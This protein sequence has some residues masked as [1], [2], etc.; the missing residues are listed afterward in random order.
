MCGILGIVSQNRIINLKER[1][2]EA[3]N[4]M[5]HRGPD[6]EGFYADNNCILVHKRLAIIDIE[7]G[8]QPLYN[9]DRRY[10]LVFNGEIYNYQELRKILI[11]RGHNIR[12]NSD[13]EVIVHLFEDEGSECLYKLR[14][15]FAFAIWDKKERRLFLAR[16]RL[17]IKP[18]YYAILSD[19]SLVFA[20]EIKAILATGQV[21]ADL[22]LWALREYLSFK[23]TIGS[24]TFFKNIWALQPGFWAKWRDGRFSLQKYWDHQYLTRDITFKKAKEEFGEIFEDS[25]NSHLV[26]D[27]P[28]GLFLSGG[29]DTTINTVTA[30]KYYPGKLHT[31]TCG[32]ENEKGGD[33]HY[34]R[35]VANQCRTKHCEIIHN[36]DE[37][38]SFMK[39]SIWYLDEPGGGSTA[40]HA[41]YVSKRAVK[42]VKVLISG[43]GAD[44]IFG[45][46]FH[47]W[48]ANYRDIPFMKRILNYMEWWKWSKKGFFNKGIK[49]LFSP[50]IVGVEEMFL[51]RHTNFSLASQEY[52]LDQSIL[53]STKGFSPREA[54]APMLNN[55]DMQHP[56]I[57]L[58]S[59]DLR[60]YL[61]RILHI[62]DRMCMAATLENRVPF[63]DHKVVEFAMSIPH[64]VL[65]YNLRSKA[66]IRS[67]LDGKIDKSVVNRKKIGFSLPVDTWF[68]RDIKVKVESA[69]MSLK[70]RNLF[71]S[72]AIDKIWDSFLCKQI[73]KEII[74]QLLSIEYWFV[75]FIDK[76][77]R[78]N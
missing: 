72:K 59:L 49:E 23:F 71:N 38:A 64:Q 65:L 61:Y 47:Y 29:L 73:S 27:V 53:E 62:Y 26:S 68:R 33:L 17:G 45:G 9:E 11:H 52:V 51:L 54:I 40:V 13:S 37:F 8:E 30:A 1:I 24:R 34:S 3:G 35:I 6:G 70:S 16:D 66:L 41:Y 28:V 18:L 60:T 15:M 36:A 43:E 56:C 74:W 39:D 12:S 31:Y 48:L 67:F 32:T 2:L 14:G 55:V 57:Q 7:G 19:G 63:L 4:T 22:C 10:V 58:M 75:N 78:N 50:S 5:N 42:D 46:Y 44:E 25:V 20:S 77:N 69:L 76:G 21:N